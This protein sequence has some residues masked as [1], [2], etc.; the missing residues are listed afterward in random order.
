MQTLS[1]PYFTEPTRDYVR[2]LENL[3]PLLSNLSHLDFHLIHISFG[4]E[5]TNVKLPPSLRSLTTSLHDDNYNVRFDEVGLDLNQL[6]KLADLP[7][8]DKLTIMG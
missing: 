4:S 2:I 8:L 6:A 5:L 1:L 3:F 7:N